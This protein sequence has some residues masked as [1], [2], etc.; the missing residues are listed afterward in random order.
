[1]R[2][3]VDQSQVK[4]SICGLFDWLFLSNT[5]SSFNI[6][7]SIE[8]SGTQ[9]V[10]IAF[11]RKCPAIC[12]Q[13]RRMYLIVLIG[14]ILSKRKPRSKMEKW[15]FGWVEVARIPRI[16]TTQHLTFVIHAEFAAA[17]TTYS[18]LTLSF[19]CLA[20]RRECARGWLV[21]H[22][23]IFKCEPCLF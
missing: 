16:E 9:S 22:L 10:F 3:Y 8:N 15:L 21:L 11:K 1:M 14:L 17:A 7:P 18:F 4:N 5:F 23:H 2:E 6:W 13:Q 19:V 20:A 12:W